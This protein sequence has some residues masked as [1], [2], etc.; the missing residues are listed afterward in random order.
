[1]ENPCL[2]TEALRRAHR[3][4]QV[5]PC[6]PKT[7][8]P[9][10]ATGFKAATTDPDIIHSWWCDTPAAVIGVPTGERF[11]VIDVDL[12]HEDAQAWL[13]DNR[14]RLPLTARTGPGRAV[15]TCCSSRTMA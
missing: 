2:W 9:L 15:S 8:R 11:V 6:D 5:F 14:H 1:M 10:V 3:G 12:Q 4:I 7:K 13:E